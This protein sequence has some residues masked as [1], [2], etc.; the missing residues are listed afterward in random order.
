M[1]SACVIRVLGMSPKFTK[2]LSLIWVGQSSHV[3]KIKY[4]GN[5]IFLPCEYFGPSWN[6]PITSLPGKPPG[7]PMSITRRSGV[8]FTV[9]FLVVEQQ[10]ASC[11]SIGAHMCR[12]LLLKYFYKLDSYSWIVTISGCHIRKTREILNLDLTC[13]LKFIP[14]HSLCQVIFT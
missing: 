13:L 3:S 2:E 4:P 9:V 5:L 1:G 12:Y 10:H 7:S 8:R 11:S 14:G 6:E